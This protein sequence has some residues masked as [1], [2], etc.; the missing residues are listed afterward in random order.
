VLYQG[1]KQ[2]NTRHISTPGLPL[3]LLFFSA[4][5]R[6]YRLQEQLAH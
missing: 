6:S 2:G 3:Y 4:V 5:A 1:N